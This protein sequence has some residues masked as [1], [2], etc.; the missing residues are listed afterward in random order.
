MSGR[1]WDSRGLPGLVTPYVLHAIFGCL[2]HSSVET[3]TAS[4]DFH[5]WKITVTYP[6][7]KT[8]YQICL[9]QH[10][11]E[12]TSRC[13]GGWM[14]HF[15]G[16]FNKAEGNLINLQQRSLKLN[17]LQM[18][19]LGAALNSCPLWPLSETGAALKDQN[20]LMY[21]IPFPYYLEMTLLFTIL[22]Q[23]DND[24]SP[25]SQLYLQ[26]FEFTAKNTKSYQVF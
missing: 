10:F 15:E 24:K 11:T 9:V 6:T 14:M 2:T 18:F 20:K 22:M 7:V 5:L 19:S 21:F 8:I 3:E 12:I 1:R 17:L 4:G 23:T 26:F 16:Y 25:Q 13:L